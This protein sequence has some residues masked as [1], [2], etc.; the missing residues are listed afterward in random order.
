MEIK[1]AGKI[2][3]EL[4]G[5][6]IDHKNIALAKI[7]FSLRHDLDIHCLIGVNASQ[8]NQNDPGKFF[9]AQVAMISDVTILSKVTRR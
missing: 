4:L 8:I 7:L 5:S 9:F 1:M 3:E 2:M 6:S